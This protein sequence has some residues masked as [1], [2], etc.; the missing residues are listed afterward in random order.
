MGQIHVGNGNGFDEFFVDLVR[1]TTAI[2]RDLF[3]EIGLYGDTGHLGER[4]GGSGGGIGVFIA[5]AGQHLIHDR[6]VAVRAEESKSVRPEV[7]ALADAPHPC[8]IVG[9]AQ[10]R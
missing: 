5:Q 3:G 8:K 9:T 4:L 6:R 1:L 7:G 10:H 2:Q